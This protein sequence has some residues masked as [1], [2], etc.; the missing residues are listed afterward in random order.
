MVELECHTGS[1]YPCFQCSSYLKSLLG[2][3]NS[4]VSGAPTR[5]PELNLY[6]H[7]KSL[8]IV[9]CASNSSPVKAEIGG[10]LGLTG[11]IPG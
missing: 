7:M 9:P 10:S 1:M 2:W 6:S 5:G 3:G 8:D 11:P 4:S